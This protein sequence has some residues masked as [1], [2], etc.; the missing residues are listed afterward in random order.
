M[1][2]LV[3]GAGGMLGRDVVA[4]AARAATTAWACHIGSWT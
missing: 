3:A 1:R 4:A 2:L